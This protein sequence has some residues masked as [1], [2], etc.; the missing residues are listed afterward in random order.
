MKP[1]SKLLLLIVLLLPVVGQAAAES[2]DYEPVKLIRPL[3]TII[4]HELKELG[5]VNPRA[6]F[7][8]IVGPKGEMVDYLA[9]SATHVGLLPKAEEKLSKARFKAATLDGVP[10]TGKITVIITFFDPEQRAWKQG[11]AGAPMGG[12][13]SDAVARK[14]YRADPDAVA[15]Q[16]SKPTELDSPLTLAE[17]KLYRLHAPDAEPPSGAVIAEYFIDHHGQVRLPEIIK[18]DNEYLSMSVI[19]SLRETRFVEPTNGGRPTYVRVRQ[20]FNFD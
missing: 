14:L 19:M 20:P 3:E 4:P 9:V 15:F 5:M 6:S 12:N 16:E 2:A 11:F 18:S 8:V 17:T 7:Q 13:V 1:S 10:T